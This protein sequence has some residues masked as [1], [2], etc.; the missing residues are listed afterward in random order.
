V[1]GLVRRDDGHVRLAPHLGWH[2]EPLAARLSE[3][4]GMPV[5]A[6][7]DA[8]LGCRAELAFGAGIGASDLIYLNGGPSGIG[9]GIVMDGRAVD[10]T[11]GYA[12]EIGHL[13]V[14]P[15]GPVCACGARGCLEALVTRDALV[16]AVGIR[17]AD[18]DELEAAVVAAVAT[19]PDGGPVS[20]EVHRQ[21]RWLS[22]ALR[23]AVNLLN[24]QRIILG[25]HL[26][27]LWIAARPADRADAL[28]EA[29]SVSARE[30]RIEVAALGGQRLLV[31]A[32]EI[33]WDGPIADPLAGGRA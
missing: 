9:G 30:A 22:I 10:G 13:C 16:A 3:A 29:L 12:G 8:H 18:D 4:L 7:N 17:H 24:P 2:D 6:A 1:P 21:L 11:A 32:A 31:G 15:D 33:A 19:E 23:G 5:V 25:G 28:V 27:A 26:A 20:D 14:D